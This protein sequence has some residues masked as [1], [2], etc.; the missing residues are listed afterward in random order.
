M[1]VCRVFRG[2]IAPSVCVA[3]W[4]YLLKQE[5]D[6]GRS[7]CP[8][9]CLGE[10]QRHL[11]KTMLSVLSDCL[12]QTIH[13]FIPHKDSQASVTFADN[14]EPAAPV[15]LIHRIFDTCRTNFYAA[16]LDSRLEQCLPCGCTSGQVSWCLRSLDEALRWDK[17]D[18]RALEHPGTQILREDSEETDSCGFN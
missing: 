18:R 17:T 1:P 3:G 15:S 8:L 16:S 2:H 6:T 10:V 13:S 4:P 9:P 12:Y 11:R 14:D 7:R 5:G